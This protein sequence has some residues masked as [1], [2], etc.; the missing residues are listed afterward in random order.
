MTKHTKEILRRLVEIG[1]LELN[2]DTTSKA[3][4]EDELDYFYVKDRLL[5]IG[6]RLETVTGR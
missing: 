1:V 3:S 5:E 2:Q 6:R 4:V